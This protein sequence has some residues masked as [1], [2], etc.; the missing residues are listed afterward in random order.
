[1]VPSAI[2]V[3]FSAS[4]IVYNNECQKPLRIAH[5]LTETVLNPK[6]TE[7]VNV[8]LSMVVFHESTVHALKHYGYNET[9]AFI[10]QVLKLWTILNVS[11]PDLGKRKQNIAYD[12]IKL[13]DDWKLG[14]ILN[15]GEYITVWEE[16]KVNNICSFYSFTKKQVINF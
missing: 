8:K 10:E 3:K 5:R 1:M 13:P 9:A 2:T 16:P 7:K 11:N 12:P 4:E 15:F 14:F 6:S